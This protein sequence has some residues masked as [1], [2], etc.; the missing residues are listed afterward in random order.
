MTPPSTTPANTY[1][2]WIYLTWTGISAAADTGRT[3]AIFYDLQWDS[4]TNQVTWTS[5]IA[6]GICKITRRLS[7]TA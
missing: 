3:P 6:S 2:N 4:G 1:P 5:L 7:A